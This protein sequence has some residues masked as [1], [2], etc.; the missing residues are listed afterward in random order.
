[1]LDLI[2]ILLSIVHT[3]GK[4]L[5]MP[6]QPIIPLFLS[7]GLDILRHWLQF[8]TNNITWIHFISHGEQYLS[9][10]QKWLFKYKTGQWNDNLMPN[11]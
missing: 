9:E 3:S 11:D 7:R 5:L 8:P 2:S 1:M 4:C 10:R 6:E